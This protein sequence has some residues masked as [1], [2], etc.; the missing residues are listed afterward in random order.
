MLRIA[1]FNVNGIRA[2][3]RRGFAQ[4]LENSGADVVCLQ[5]VRAREK[6]IPLEVFD[7]W[8][9]HHHE[10]DQAGRNGVAIL[11][12]VEPTAV[13][14]GFG[15]AEFDAQGRYL[16]VE[17]PGVTVGSLYLPKGDTEG[18]KFDSKH[19]FMKE[20]AAH[21]HATADAG[22]ELV[23]CGDY[24]IAHTNSDIKSWKT[25]LKSVGFLPSEREWIADLV[26]TG[27][28]VDVLRSLHPD[29]DG[30]YSWWSWRGKAFDND[31]GWRID[32]HVATPGLA[33]TA[34]RAWV[35]RE[36]SYAER[37]SDHAAVLADYDFPFP[38]A[39]SR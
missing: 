28:F 35:D 19:R 30:P 18:E 22:R 32:H 15:S 2:V 7:G 33:A 29:V 4:W 13:R 5:E 36:P 14:A 9:F 21:M 20:L 27:E 11:S 1:T 17:L 8:H 34:T 26:T 31:S 10:A 23:V 16:E 3:V 25:N 39:P 37:L 24:N 12:R 6:D 38:A